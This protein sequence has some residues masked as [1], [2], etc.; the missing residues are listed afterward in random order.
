M[1][2]MAGVKPHVLLCPDKDKLTV[3]EP[4]D[5]VWWCSL[6][7]MGTLNRKVEPTRLL[8]EEAPGL[9][10][11]CGYL[12]TGEVGGAHSLISAPNLE[13]AL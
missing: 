8:S 12:A 2:W 7:G 1:E 9:V 6:L 3:Q 4:W 11:Q 5:P 10:S 13:D